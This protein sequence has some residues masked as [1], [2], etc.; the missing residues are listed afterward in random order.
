MRS[1]AY[2]LLAL[3]ISLA[4]P[5]SARADF[6]PGYPAF[7]SNTFQGNG[8]VA[9]RFH[10]DVDTL[11]SLEAMI[12]M[13]DARRSAT[14]YWLLGQDNELLFG[15]QFY[16]PSAAAIERHIEVGAAGLVMDEHYGGSFGEGGMTANWRFTKAGTY[17]VVAV[18][19][20]DAPVRARINM[21]ASDG[22]EEISGTNGQ[23]TFV[24]ADADFR[25]TANFVWSEGCLPPYPYW[26]AC[27]GVA[28]QAQVQTSVQVNQSLF[29]NFSSSGV[30]SSL[31]WEGPANTGGKTQ[32][33]GSGFSFVNR[34]SGTYTLGADL[35]VG[36]SL[37]N[38]IS[39]WG[40]DVLLPS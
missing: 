24:L 18:A 10:A 34:A 1:R 15:I 7:S 4:V 9:E 29:G 40:A 38:G 36:A 14:G 16:G 3:A 39:A 6:D 5:A 32:G 31:W 37:R 22:L 35:N 27:Q 12:E 17:T 30:A 20:S 21:H 8:W 2:I 33:S 23:E 11:F 13:K 26:L 28:A 25:G 19:M